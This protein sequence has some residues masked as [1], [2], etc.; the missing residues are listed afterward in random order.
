[1]IEILVIV[2]Y[3]ELEEA[4]HKAITRIKIKEVN[5]TTTY[6]FGT[7]TK[8]IEAV[9]KYDI[10]VVRG[11]TS[12]AISKLYPDLHKVEISI[13]S[14]DILD[15]LLEVREKFGN[16]KVALIVS[17]SSICSP[18][19]I[20]KLTGMEI[21][22]FTIYDEE[23]LENKVDNL[24][25]LGFEVF[26]GGLT[27]KKICANNG[28]NYVQIK[29]GVTAIDQSIRDA[30][31]AAHIL[32]R[33]RTRSDLL[34]A[35]ADSAQNGLFV[36]NNYKT[37]IAAN[38]VSENFF[39]VPSL[40]G[41]DATQFYPD[42]LLNITLNNGSDLEIVQTLYG[43]T[44]LVIQNRFIG[45]GESRGVIVSLQKVSDIYATEKKIRSKLATKGLVAKCHFSD[46]VAE[47]FVMRQLIAKALR[48]A[49]V[50]SN[51]LV[52]GETGTGKELIVQSMHNASLR[53]N[54]PF[55][56]VNC[57]A[58]SEQ[59]LESELFGYTEGAFTGASKGGK[60]GLFE[61]AHK[62][63]IFLDEI[64][65]MPIQVQAK[66]LRVLQEKEVRRV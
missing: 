32:D 4:Y 47:Q 41:K 54:G 12:F 38:Q 59:L 7:G 50:D 16:K 10:V 53:A 35:L 6:L 57:A 34:K 18:A 13:T 36:V 52:T 1:M 30:L 42:S 15:A 19:V 56:A 25:E 3:Q 23:T 31:V 29:T 2:P 43:Q 39:K 51:V 48:Y 45:N 66:L 27:L 24:Q 61:L 37:I 9:K 62:G 60:V 21:E 28:Y 63:T 49:Q 44:M 14:S 55:V 58:L 20:N 17:N 33:E 40:I 26:V 11:M 46:I 5:F 8:A 65:E 64:G 22:L